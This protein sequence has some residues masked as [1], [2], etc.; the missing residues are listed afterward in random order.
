MNKFVYWTPRVL[1]IIFVLFL[2]LFSLDVFGTGL[3]FWQTALALFIHNIPTLILLIVVLIAWKYEIVGG[4]GFILAGILYI[5]FILLNI[6]TTGFQW[7]YLSWAIQI[8][9]I[10]FLVG[11]MF[12][13]GWFKKKK[14]IK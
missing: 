12:L 14:S 10:A 6:S 8:S 2:M 1:S 13:V 4:V 9:G 11:I 5:V 7:Y 3:N